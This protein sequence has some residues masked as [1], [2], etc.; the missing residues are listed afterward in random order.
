MQEAQS[1]RPNNIIKAKN[2]PKQD[3]Y[4]MLGSKVPP[5][6]KDAEM[7]VIGGLLL[8][9]GAF[10]RVVNIIDEESFYDFK[11]KEIFLAI[12]NI[13]NNNQNVDLLT[14]SEEL[15]RRGKLEEVGGNQYL[16]DLNRRSP[17][18]ANIESHALIVLEKQLK[19]L[20][21]EKS[22]SMMTNAFDDTVDIIEEIDKAENEVFKIAQK[23][24][25]KS[26]QSM[27]DISKKTMELITLLS[28]RSEGGVTGVSTGFTKMDEMLGGFQNSD[29]IILAARPSMGKTALG[30]SILLNVAVYHQQPVAFFSIEMASTQIAIRL[31]SAQAKV[32]QSKIRAGK[33]NQHENS[34]IVNGLGK[35]SD[36]PIFIDDSAMM[37]ILE[38]KA[39]CR[40]LKAEH[41]IKL[42]VVDYLQLLQA[43]KAESREREISIIS[44]SLKQIAKDLEIPVI[45]LAQL[46]RSV[47]N[48][49]DFRPMLQDLRESGSIEQDADVIMFVN[50]PERYDKD[51]L[52]DGTPS[53]GMAEIIIGKQR[54]GP[55]GN[56]KLVF[57]KDYARFENY[58]MAAED[59]PQSERDKYLEHMQEVPPQTKSDEEVQF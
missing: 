33:L 26:Y 7:A 50:R 31:V 16:A 13:F 12:K 43:P 18:A 20:L 4:T 59:I 2:Q 35:L 49:K 9:R 27:K 24:F 28:K 15:R 8:S 51:T 5:N 22:A 39:K 36:S 45:A 40:R 14:L 21:I 41:D 38:L 56:I 25:S 55:T 11:H 58:T 47:E 48:R 52:W 37:N 46:N 53:E 19:R 42:V 17:S 34:Q 29:L 23:R 44:Q 57:Q 54:N 10:S 30:L 1:T 32:D 6:S 3:L